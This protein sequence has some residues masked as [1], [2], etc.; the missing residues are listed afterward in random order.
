MPRS[1]KPQPVQA[2]AGVQG[3]TSGL[4]GGSTSLSGDNGGLVG[5]SSGST[6]GMTTDA[7]NAGMTFDQQVQLLKL[8]ADLDRER[9]QSR[10]R[11]L[12]LQLQLAQAQ[13]DQRPAH[14]DRGDGPR[15]DVHKASA[16]LPHYDEREIEMYLSNF[17]KTAEVSGWPRD[18]WSVI[19]QPKLSGKALKAYDRLTV[20]EIVDYNVVKQTI[21]DELELVAEVYRVK[22]RSCTKRVA[23]TYS[24]FAHYMSMQFDRW[25]KAEQIT[26]FES[27]KQLMLREQ[28]YDKV[29]QDLKVHVSEKK[30]TSLVE[31][32]RAADEYAV[33]HK[34]AGKLAV[35]S[36]AGL[37]GNRVQ[38]GV[39]QS[40]L[41]GAS[42]PGNRAAVT[43]ARDRPGDY[44]SNTQVEFK[45]EKDHNVC[46]YCHL[47]GHRIRDCNKRK[48]DQ[49]SVVSSVKGYFESRNMLCDNVMV[50]NKSSNKF[51]LNEYVVPVSIHNGAG[52]E[53]SVS[54][55]RDTGAQVSLLRQA[56]VPESC[57]QMLDQT[58]RIAGVGSAQ[59][60]EIPLCKIKVKSAMVTGEI[61]VGLTPVSFSMPSSTVPLLLG[62]DYGPQ[63]SWE[64]TVDVNAVVTRR[65]AKR[66]AQ[67]NDVT[68]DNKEVSELE[69]TGNTNNEVLESVRN[70][71]N[72]YESETESSD[73]LQDLQRQDATL[74]DIFD[75]MQ[76]QE[77]EYKGYFV[78]SNG[79]LMHKC[80]GDVHDRLVDGAGV[81]IVLPRNLRGAVLRLAHDIPASGHLGIGKTRKR[82]LPYF[83]WPGMLR[84]IKNY[85]V[86]CDVCQRNNKTGKVNREPMKLTPII[87]KAFSRIS[88]DVA[89]PLVESSR[90]NRF[91]LTIVDHGTRW[92]EAYPIADHKATTVVRSL[93]DFIARFGIPEEVLHD[94]GSDFMS[95]LMQVMLSFY[96]ITQLKS[97]VAHPQTNTAVERFHRTLKQMLR[98]F[99]DKYDAEWD[100]ALPHLL[101]A[102][103]EIPVAEYGFS[104]YE[105]LFG[106]YVRGPLSVL[107]DSWWESGEHQ[108]SPHVVDYMVQLRD[109][110]EEALEYAHKK[111]EEAQ[112]ESKEWYDRK[113]RAVSYKAGDLVLVLMPMPGK[114]LCMKYIGP[115]KIMK[116][117]SPVDYLVEFP[118]G[119]KP[120]RV[121]HANLLKHYHTRVDYV[122]EDHVLPSISCVNFTAAVEDNGEE[123]CLLG[124]PPPD[125]Y[126]LLMK[127]KTAHLTADKAKQICDLINE[128]K[129]VVSDKPGLTNLYVHSIRLKP[130]AR[131][132]RLRPYRMSPKH[133]DLLRKEI[134]KLLAD[135]IIEE[136]TSDWSSPAILV[137]KPG[138]SVRCVIDYRKVNSLVEDESYPIGRIDDLIDKVGKAKY[139]TKF[140]LSS[141]FHQIALDPNSRQY[142]SFCT[143]FG[144]FLYKRLPFGYKISPMKLSATL[145]K[146][147][148]GLHD[149]CGMYIDDIV[150]HSETW[151]Q[152]LT[153]V[154]RVLQRLLQARLT[155]RL[156]KCFFACAEV[157]YLG[158]TVGIGRISP[159]QATVQSLIDA[160]APRNKKQLRSFLGL[161]GFFQRYIPHYANLTAPLTD[162]LRKG[163]DFNWDLQAETAFQGI[164]K[165]MCN[166][167]ILLIA[168]YSKPFTMFIDASNVA[169]GA[170]LMQKDESGDLKPVCYFSKKLNEAQRNYAVRDKEALALVLAVRAFRVYLTGPVDVYTDHE[171]LKFINS[172]AASNQRILR[173]ALELQSYQLNI[174]HVRG[175]DNKLADYFSRPCDA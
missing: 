26:D 90:G 165:I 82:V 87:E 118:E 48:R 148:N 56:S 128:F 32:A 59:L 147:L 149:C 163:R 160:T 120:T 111:Q 45:Q 154:R 167:P 138:G 137:P 80:V 47:P 13:R 175:K 143:P 24:D 29:P 139:L 19:L 46:Y 37:S 6:G 91:V 79:V 174:I 92:V 93:L 40:T 168:D 44:R 135:D 17:E 71:F 21:L 62:N 54:C 109:R 89:G 61:V 169:I 141:S 156:V 151:D 73:K 159:R 42:G 131:P 36:R 55:W 130:G 78:H 50:S 134:D 70:L 107:F 23:E 112:E 102:F 58:V 9:A 101:F 106:R 25:T 122:D 7:S 129:N 124:P 123:P 96:G 116:Q 39:G 51:A 108:A 5:A 57:L 127:E 66:I 65:Q 8:Q 157:D 16:V 117:T 170:V 33:L 97:S 99:L 144:Q 64:P 126:A 20:V 28:F 155:V 94:L 27:L 104:P 119:R 49:P 136:S 105:L 12:E 84:D 132:V 18:K 113:A 22:F 76:G 68:S 150:V 133:Q 158:H 3:E 63:M 146:A 11:E 173:W 166:Q 103:R 142:T 145:A 75:R 1:K 125:D 41:T 152:H 10:Q 164:K 140:D 52:D 172:M 81:Q 121:L 4:A 74:A 88:L 15:F 35:P 14:P 72:V 2:A 115:Y 43:A 31:V 95:E 85:C 171:P 110:L 30:R 86:T 67:T 83:Y 98:A 114:P 34:G 69:K 38:N 161:A 153:D 162:T 53:V 100:D 77:G 60:D